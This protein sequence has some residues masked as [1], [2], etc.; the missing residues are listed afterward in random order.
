MLIIKIPSL[1]ICH[2]RTEVVDILVNI[3]CVA[4]YP[5]IIQI[6]YAFTVS[7]TMTFGIILVISHTY[8]RIYYNMII[9]WIKCILFG[10]I[11]IKFQYVIAFS[12]DNLT[13]TV[14]G[15][16]LFYNVHIVL[17]CTTHFVYIVH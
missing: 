13:K 4:T 6:C 1:S 3:V 7:I 8:Y 16:A 9:S 17:G 12:R 10:K 2:V 5:V 15:L 11:W 14:N